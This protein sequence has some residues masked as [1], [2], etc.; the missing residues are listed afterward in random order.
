[1]NLFRSKYKVR[2]TGRLVLLILTLLIAD[3][4]ASDISESNKLAKQIEAGYILHD[5]VATDLLLDLDGYLKI[6]MFNNPG[7]RSSFYQ[8][9]AELENVSIVSGLPNPTFSYGYF[10]ENVETRV[11]PQ[12]HKFS[13]RQSFPWFGTLSAKGDIAYESANAAYQKY[14]SEKLNLFFQVKAAYYN[15]Y[16]LGQEIRLTQE[17]IELLKFWESV[18]RV[19]YKTGQTEHRDLIKIQVELGKLEERIASLKARIKP[20]RQNLLFILGF[21][22]DKNLPLPDSIQVNN[23]VLD[24]GLINERTINHNPDLKAITH[25]VESNQAR[26]NL[27]K[28]STMPSFTIGFDYI[29]TGDALNPVLDES[30]KDP[31][32]VNVGISLPIWFGKN[33][34]QKKRA[35]AQ[36]LMT[37]NRMTDKIN[38]LYS[39]IEKLRYEIEDASRKI[40]LYRDGLI[41]KAEQSLNVSYK[42]YQV[43]DSDFL[44]VLDAQR[45][46]LDFRLKFQQ[47]RVMYAIKTAELEALMGESIESN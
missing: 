38:Q 21:S 1:M 4:F 31:W 2:R 33:S 32:A 23:S 45:Q 10:V 12:E 22:E 27:A 29:M 15:Y 14:Q 35:K 44:E 37:E 19:K 7:L 42:A 34:A 24:W 5:A 16:Y 30:G 26:I 28:K 11:G 3:A 6:A 8:W 39:L 25:L 9:K 40:S 17:D 43:G 36:Y 41:I 47:A 46:L 18:V 20:L 13:L